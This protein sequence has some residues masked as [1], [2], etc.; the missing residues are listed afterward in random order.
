MRKTAAEQR[1]ELA[2]KYFDL[3]KLELREARAYWENKDQ[4]PHFDCNINSTKDSITCS[5]VHYSNALLTLKAINNE[6]ENLS[7]RF[8][9][10]AELNEFCQRVKEY[11][12]NWENENPKIVAENKR[13]TE[14]Y[15][16]TSGLNIVANRAKTKADRAEKEA[17]RQARRA[18]RRGTEEAQKAAEE[19][20]EE[21]KEAKKAAEEA[22]KAAKE[23]IKSAEKTPTKFIV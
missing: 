5:M 9:D 17:E 15:K 1:Q 23:A 14:I 12:V 16:A 21:A 20:A 7:A 4:H 19:A 22:E 11:L 6:F 8:S 13:Q 2:Q 18:Q 10:R 3:M